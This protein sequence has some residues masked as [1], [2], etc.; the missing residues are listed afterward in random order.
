MGWFISKSG[1]LSPGIRYSHLLKPSNEKRDSSSFV[2]LGCFIIHNPIAIVKRRKID[3]D[4]N[5]TDCPR[6]LLEILTP[7]V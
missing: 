6:K 7:G 4:D 2:W 3:D 1:A 5:S